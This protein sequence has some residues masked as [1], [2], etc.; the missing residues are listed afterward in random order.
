MGGGRLRGVREEGK[1]EEKAEE[2]RRETLGGGGKGRS[3]GEVK[4]AS[5]E[6]GAPKGEITDHEG[7]PWGGD[8]PAPGSPEGKGGGMKFTVNLKQVRMSC[9]LSFIFNKTEE[10]E[11]I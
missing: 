2:Q 9:L 4:K 5:N 7:A 8:S 3:Y 1:G 11:G 6:S 10:M